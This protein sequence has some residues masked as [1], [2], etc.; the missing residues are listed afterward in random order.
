MRG[1]AKVEL[2]LRGPSL[3]V[4]GTGRHVLSTTFTTIGGLLPLL[5]FVGGDF[6]LP[7]A[8]VLAG[9]VAGA[10]ILATVFVPAGYLLLV[11]SG[12]SRARSTAMPRTAGMIASGSMIPAR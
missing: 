9:G 10:T 6:W 11:R 8:V 7:L 12:R 5:I 4:L 2:E 3:A 1:H